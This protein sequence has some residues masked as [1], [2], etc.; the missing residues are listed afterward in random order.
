MAE[1]KIPY[2]ILIEMTTLAHMMTSIDD[3]NVLC[4]Y[5]T[6]EDFYD[7]RHQKVF[8]AIFSLYKADSSVERNAVA[9]ELK[10][11]GSL[12][13][14]GGLEYLIEICD[15]HDPYTPLQEYIRI[16]K[17]L[18]VLRQ[19]M[20]ISKES[21]LQASNSPPQ[22]GNFLENILKRLGQI[23]TGTKRRHSFTLQELLD[24][25]LD[26]ENLSFCKKVEK[27]NEQANAGMVVMKGKPSH[28]L[29]L[30]KAIQG[31]S[32]GHLTI[33]GA[34]PGAGKTSMM[35]NLALQQM[36]INK[37]SA[38]IF[39]LEMG[40]LE[41]AE[42]L[43]CLH[44]DLSGQEIDR[45]KIDKNA[46]HR[47]YG[48]QQE[49][50]SHYLVIEDQPAITFTQLKSRVKR[51]MEIKPVDIV[52]VDYIQLLKGESKYDNMVYDLG[53]TSQ[54]LKSLSKEFNIPVIC[55]A[56]LNRN[57]E[58][59]TGPEKSPKLSDLRQSGQLEQDADEV[60]LLHRPEMYDPYQEPGIMRVVIAKNRFGPTGE[61]RLAFNK[62]TGKLTNYTSEVPNDNYGVF[63]P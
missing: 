18:S 61:F 16:L 15:K 54:N 35:L 4:E 20:Q 10:K 46:I 52:F 62:A 51:Q 38:M 13:E 44:A 25:T 19:I 8:F 29:D 33:I 30:D 11:M 9:H 34:R 7:K 24:G 41:L 49:I 53:E 60:L 12:Q 47:L 50:I 28:Y 1:Q 2:N 36:L 55:L 14:I 56:Q 48:K 63:T 40:A 26:P 21:Y 58:Q 23:Q 22:V 43:L 42:K 57:V 37:S 39:S 17:E 59:R 27:I 5:I 6:P 3:L 45:G 31:F 32:P